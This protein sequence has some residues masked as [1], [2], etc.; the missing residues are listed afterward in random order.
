MPLC[1]QGHQSAD[2]DY[3]SEC[4]VRI[5]APALAATAAIAS[6]SSG[7]ICPD[8]GT[9]RSAGSRFCEVCRYDFQGKASYAASAPVALPVT[10]ATAA[11]AV[12]AQPTA[13]APA[14]AAPLATFAPR[15]QFN[16]EIIVD[17]ALAA[18]ADIAAA[19]PQDAPMR[20]FPLDLEENL[21][22]RRSDVKGV[23]PEIQVDDPGVSR[24]HLKLLRQP[25][26]NYAA[27]DLGSTNGSVF[28]GA[29]LVPGLLTPLK[30]GD[31]IV[32]GN[33]TKLRIALKK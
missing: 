14:A 19:C 29:E 17:P 12:A 31:E 24:R 15:L 26:G 1:S 10:A 20:F 7:E 18:D 2:S 3:C 13:P 27:L 6:A 32:V 16:V 25:D 23:Y 33:W 21:V 8:C 11:A 28:N 9:P 22:G 5:G 30:P 4:G